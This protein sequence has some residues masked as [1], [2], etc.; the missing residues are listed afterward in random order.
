MGASKIPGARTS[1]EVG[2]NEDHGAAIDHGLALCLANVQR[3]IEVL[4]SA[5]DSQRYY[6]FNYEMYRLF[7]PAKDGQD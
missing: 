5:D 4:K 3:W 1:W 2:G 6:K 7:Y